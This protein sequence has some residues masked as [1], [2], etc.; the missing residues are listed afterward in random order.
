MLSFNTG[1]DL[2]LSDVCNFLS[3]L[4]LLGRIAMQS[5]I[6]QLSTKASARFMSEDFSLLTES[7]KAST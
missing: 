6:Q 1:W 7:S 4:G 5:T 2:G 3:N